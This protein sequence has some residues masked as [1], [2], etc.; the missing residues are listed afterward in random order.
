VRII[1]ELDYTREAQNQ[2]NF[3]DLYLEHPFIR[4]PRVFPSHSTGRVLTSEYVAGKRFADVL[5]LD[6]AERDRYG[7][8][9]YRFV[10]GSILRFGVFNGDPHPGNYLFDE[11][12]RVVFLDFGCV[13]YF[14]PLMLANWKALVTAHLRNDRDEFGKRLIELGFIPALSDEE[15]HTLFDYFGYFYEPFHDDRRFTFSREYN[16]KSFR[17]IF[18]P[19]DR[20]RGYEK[21]LNMPADFVFVNRIQ[22][23]VYSILADLGATANWNRIDAEFRLGAEPETE[24]GRAD[25][26]FF[27]RWCAERRLSGT[28]RLLPEGVRQVA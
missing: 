24:L 9:L 7:E 2:S 25:R 22:W 10:F 23:G 15:S 16:R 14:P 6:T 1:E 28:V 8:I 18:K 21:K 4:V 13:K 5:T 26:D 3:R 11:E 20:F 17:M 27:R 12:G 19:E